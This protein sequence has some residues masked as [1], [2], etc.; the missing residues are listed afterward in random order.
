MRDTITKDFGWKLLSLLL[1][2]IIW[3]TVRTGSNRGY[4]SLVP[5]ADW[6]TRS[7]TNLPVHIR[8]VPGDV[9]EFTMDTDVVDV[10]ISGSPEDIEKLRRQQIHAI[11][12]VTDIETVLGTIRTPVDVLTPIGTTVDNVS[13]ASVGVT[14]SPKQVQQQ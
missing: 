4:K 5:R 2:G 3:Y 7:F 12:D 8:S 13:P 10:T 14:V 11:V 6:S 9:R 1:A